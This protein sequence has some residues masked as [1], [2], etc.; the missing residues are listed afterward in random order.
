MGE[1]RQNLAQCW[2]NIQASL[3]PFLEEVLDPLSEKQQ[4]LVT[5]LE[6][7]R[8][9]GYVPNYQWYE[10]RPRKTRC[11]IARSFVAKMVYNISTTRALY[12]R[13]RSDKNVRRICGW[14]NRNSIPSES[15]FS[16][17][18]AEFAETAL[19]Q[20]VHDALIK[21][22][23]VETDTVVLHNS[24]DST[25]IE[26]REKPTVKQ[27]EPE[28]KS[29]DKKPA[30]KGRPKR[31][32]EKPPKEPTRI[33]KQKTMPLETMLK[34]LSVCCDVGTKKNSKGNCVRW[35]GYKLHID[36]ADGG[37]PI[38]AIL[39]SASVHDSQV[40]I[41]LAAMTAGKVRNLYDLMDAAYDVPGIL[42][43][44]RSL[45][46]VPLVDKNPR[47]DKDLAD[48]LDAEH[49][50]QRLI[51]MVSPEK[52]RYNER[53]TAERVNSRLKDD[54]GGRN[55]RVRGSIKVACHLMFGILV[56]AADQLLKLVT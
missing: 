32:E 33:E 14:E 13:L 35:I 53:T 18:F 26:A 5:I 30:K 11:A 6:L 4:Q 29:E 8:I 50:R 36:T 20:K 7:I 9:E 38:S 52:I 42:D 49:K 28:A 34:D 15:T 54:F 43:Y 27:K 51:H 55:V 40:A 16:R 25:A 22:M 41:P 44:S 19:P 1:L 45:G 46:H 39:T 3:F 56:L 21:K 47:R 2:S 23:Y 31:G 37:V 10:G 12:E 17:A 48:E 24:R